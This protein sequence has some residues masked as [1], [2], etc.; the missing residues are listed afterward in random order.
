M[1]YE[2]A[3]QA[4]IKDGAVSLITVP[5]TDVPLAR[6]GFVTSIEN[7]QT[8]YYNVLLIADADDADEQ[9]NVTE[10]S[11]SVPGFD[12]YCIIATKT[13]G[14][15]TINVY[16][17]P[18]SK[19]A[20]AVEKA[21]NDFQGWFEGGMG[22]TPVVILNE[23]FGLCILNDDGGETKLFTPWTRTNPDTWCSDTEDYS[24]YEWNNTDDSDD[25]L[26]EIY[27]KEDQE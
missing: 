7:P 24:D 6:V 4:A 19:G 3:I 10:I 25:T 1:S 15:F 16:G 9:D 22:P 11:T 8:V 14:T 2:D 27:G 20:Y 23:T 5:S 12:S 18:E 26:E 21:I 13:I 17:T